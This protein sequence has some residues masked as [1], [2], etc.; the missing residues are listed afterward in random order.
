MNAEQLWET[1]MNPATRTLK[2][3]NIDDFKSAEE[4]VVLLMGSQVP[5]RRKFIEENSKQN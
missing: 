3:V 5:P 2:R 4:S 1:T